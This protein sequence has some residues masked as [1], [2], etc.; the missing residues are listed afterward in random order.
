MKKVGIFL[1]GGGG[2]GSYHIG[3][4]KALE[5]LD[6]KYDLVC[7]TSVG[8]LV[9]GAAT[10]LD[11]YEMFECWKTLTLESVL[12]VDSRKIK[13]L[14][15][16][17]RNLMLFKETFLSCCRKDPNLLIDINDIRNLLYASLDGEKIKNSK[18]DFG[19]STT[20]LPSFKMVN[21]FKEDMVDANVLEYI[22]AAIY[23]PIFTGQKIINNK[24]YIDISRWRRYPLE[25]LKEKECDEIYIVNI[26][27]KN[28]KKLEIPIK[29]IFDD[30]TIVHF[31]NMEENPSILDFEEEQAKRNLQNGYNQTLKLLKK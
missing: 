12:K 19:L 6:I 10:Y 28:T 4:F 23:M 11:S 22:I 2:I 30:N 14:Q 31:I 1:T 16:L 29:K 9:G 7:G 24:S 26:E 25:M 21:F 18:I 8:A 15:G 17:K 20:E 27:T 5:E 13:D 3:F